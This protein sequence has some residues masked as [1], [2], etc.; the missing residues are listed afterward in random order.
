MIKL[1]SLLKEQQEEKVVEQF[2]FEFESGQ[3]D[4]SRPG[5]VELSKIIAQIKNLIA[6]GR[7]KESSLTIKINASESKVPN[8]SPYQEE[9]S[10]AKARA[11]KLAELLKT[12]FPNVEVTPTYQPKA[13]G[14]EYDKNAGDQADDPK[15]KPF[16]KVTAKIVIEPASPTVKEYIMDFAIAIPSQ[17]GK[18][19]GAGADLRNS[20]FKRIGNGEWKSTG[21][22]NNFLS[23]VRRLSKGQIQGFN[24]D[25]ISKKT[26]DNTKKLDILLK[27][28]DINELINN[29][30]PGNTDVDRSIKMH[31]SRYWLLG[32]DDIITFL[33]NS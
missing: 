4:L 15:Y 7:Y 16:Q 1:R 14:P 24:P 6:A 30:K 20:F 2:E 19:Q 8:Q 18:A 33:E 9:G 26:I 29:Y 13:Q 31:N 3:L 12:Q 5:Q 28:K 21:S 17:A 32:I 23:D 10:L 25:E 27:Q 22:Y 11:K